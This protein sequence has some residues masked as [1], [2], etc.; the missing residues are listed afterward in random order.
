MLLFLLSF[1]LTGQAQ[2]LTSITCQV[3]TPQTYTPSRNPS[4]TSISLPYSP[5]FEG[6]LFC[7]SCC[8]FSSPLLSLTGQAQT[9]TS[10]ACHVCTP[11]T[12]TP[13]HNPS[14]TSIPLPYSPRFEGFLFCFS[15]CCFS[16]PFLSLP[17]QAQ[18]LT[19]I[20]CRP[21]IWPL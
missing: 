16:S 10:I 21:S 5:R 20:T 15:C 3:C 6:F 1:S 8:C 9:L 4:Q 17:G 18:T 7:F 14:Q 19:S 12:Y 13:S 2:T 11:H